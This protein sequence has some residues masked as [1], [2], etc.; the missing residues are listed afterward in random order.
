M[1]YGNLNSNF[2]LPS[3]Y[4][5]LRY[6]FVTLLRA[7][8]ASEI[9]DENLRYSPDKTKRKIE[10]YPTYPQVLEFFPSIAVNLSSL[11][12]S[13]TYL[14]DELQDINFSKGTYLY[15]GIFTV[16]INM[17]VYSKSIR[18]RDRIVDHLIL[19][20]KHLFVNHFRELGIQFRKDMRVS[21]ESVN[22]IAGG[23]VYSNTISIPS[24]IEY[25]IERISDIEGIIQQINIENLNIFWEEE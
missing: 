6:N 11:N 17:T 5:K 2:K 7:A 19:F 4:E 10:I 1:I 8:F 25:E 24:S 3:I 13:H 23:I 9:T 15:N 22:P 16:D 20:F 21:D 18:E 14:E 12:F